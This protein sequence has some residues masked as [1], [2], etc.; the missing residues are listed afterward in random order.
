MTIR[1]R[2]SV[3]YMPGSNGRAIEKART[4]PVDAIILDLEDSVAPDSKAAARAR[5]V[6]AVTAGGFGL[7]EVIVRINGIDTPWHVDDLTPPPARSPTQS[8]FRRSRRR[9]SSRRS[10]SACSTCMPITDPGVGDD[11]NRRSRCSNARARRRGGGLR[12]RGLRRL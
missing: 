1:P 12:R 9:I 5:V 2:R 4:L 8:W 3:L 6:G 10:A 11:G 7:R